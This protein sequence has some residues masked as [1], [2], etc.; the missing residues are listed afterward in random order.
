[1]IFV[2]GGE[3]TLGKNK[4]FPTFGWDNEYGTLKLKIKPF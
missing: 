4:N 1:M 2:A 3:T